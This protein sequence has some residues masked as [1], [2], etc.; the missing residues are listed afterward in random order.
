VSHEVHEVRV[1]FIIRAVPPEEW[2]HE[3]GT[4]YVPLEAVVVD[5]DLETDEDE[6][7]EPVGED[8]GGD[9]PA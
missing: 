9:R 7:S 2:E 6:N 5:D 8:D 4:V 1:P 3:G